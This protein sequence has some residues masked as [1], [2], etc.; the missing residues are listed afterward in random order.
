[1]ALTPRG[2]HFFRVFLHYGDGNG[3][4]FVTLRSCTR[5]IPLFRLIRHQGIQKLIKIRQTGLFFHL[6]FVSL[7]RCVKNH[8]IYSTFRF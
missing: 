5:L 4:F 7:Q 3:T 8:L 2:E 6:L 1:M